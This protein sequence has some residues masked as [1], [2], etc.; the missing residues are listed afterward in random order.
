MPLATFPAH[1]MYWR[2]TPAV[3][4]PAFSCPVSSIAPIT[5][6]PR[7]R[8]AAASSP[9]TANRRTTAIAAQVSQLA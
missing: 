8:R 3:A 6:P 9:A 7:R 2:L 4:S 5:I 1:P